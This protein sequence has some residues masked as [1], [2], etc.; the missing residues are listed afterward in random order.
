MNA[1]AAVGGQN[2]GPTFSCTFVNAEFFAA[3]V[4]ILREFVDVLGR[5]FPKMSVA[6]FF[7]FFSAGFLK[8]CC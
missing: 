6:F 3:L 4:A 2:A 5:R 8:R 1:A 7:F